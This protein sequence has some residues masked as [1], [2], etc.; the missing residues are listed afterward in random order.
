[1]ILD[2]LQRLWNW[3]NNIG[4]GTKTFIIIV[5]LAIILPQYID[6]R[7]GFF[8]DR[9]ETCYKHYKLVAEK[10]AMSTAPLVYNEVERILMS[11]KQIQ[12]VI[13]LNYHNTRENLSGYSY[14]YVTALAEAARDQEWKQEWKE[15]DYID[16]SKEIER[17]HRK[18][19]L[20]V[21]S[22]KQIESTYPRLEK[23]L[24]F[25]EAKA[26]AIYPVEG[27]NRRLGL[28]VI[29]YKE[30]KTYTLG[31]YQE[32]IAPAISRLTSLL[33]YANITNDLVKEK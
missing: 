14:L 7:L 10:Y 32:N 1:M 16:Y 5:L 30:K 13:L 12:N 8:Q 29:L 24:D 4:S 33:D 2:R 9:Y 11:D 27:V 28:I 20:R 25:C 21:D 15:L 18:G 3:I 19:Y 31:Y 23:K 6:S 22:L 26:A 17:I